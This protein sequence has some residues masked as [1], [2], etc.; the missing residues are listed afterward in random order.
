[1][2]ARIIPYSEPFIAV[3]MN[4][5]EAMEVIAALQEQH[6]AAS[7]LLKRV[8]DE[9]VERA[10]LLQEKGRH[11]KVDSTG[12]ANKGASGSRGGGHDE[13]SAPASKRRVRKG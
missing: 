8:L 10:V 3:T 4:M 9:T 11:A 5:D 1:M 7:A 12:Q 2:H 6:D 13:P